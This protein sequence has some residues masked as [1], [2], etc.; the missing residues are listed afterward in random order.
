MHYAGEKREEFRLVNYVVGRVGSDPNQ[1]WVKQNVSPLCSKDSPAYVFAQN[2]VAC[3]DIPAG[4][5]S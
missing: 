5:N 1:V 3:P 4:I 2:L